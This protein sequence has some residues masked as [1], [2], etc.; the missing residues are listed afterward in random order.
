MGHK[1]PCQVPCSVQGRVLCIW[2]HP[3]LA[4]ICSAS[5]MKPTAILCNA[6]CRY[7]A[8]GMVLAMEAASNLK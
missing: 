3:F 2:R 1:D 6:V 5:K 4:Q 8:S 7:I